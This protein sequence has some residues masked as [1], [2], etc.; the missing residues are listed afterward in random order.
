[1]QYT[2]LVKSFA[3]AANLLL[4][5][6]NISIGKIDEDGWGC[7]FSIFS[8]Y[9]ESFKGVQVQG[10]G[11]SGNTPSWAFNQYPVFST[12]DEVTTEKEAVV[13]FGNSDVTIK[14][15]D[16]LAGLDDVATGIESVTL[17]D[18]NVPADALTINEPVGSDTGW[19][20]TFNSDFYDQIK[21]RIV[22]TLQG[23]GTKDSYLNIHRVGLDILTG[24]GG[25]G[26]ML[27]HGTGLGPIYDSTGERVIWATYYYPEAGDNAVDLYVTYTWPD[28]TITK[29]TIHNK[30]ALNWDYHHDGTSDCKSSDFVLYDG[31]EAGAP[32][33]VE[34]IAVI[35]GFDNTTTFNGAKFGAGKGVVWNNYLGSN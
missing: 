34:A 19:T 13:Y 27:F 16:Q 3:Y 22:Y 31:T 20:V 4:L 9:Q 21:V 23:G 1:M 2:Y 15:V 33:K 12:D 14:P 18:S 32:T 25:T 6:V 28:G 10:T 35:S 17:A 5:I 8:F 30:P 11:A 29:D 7:I 26:T 24:H